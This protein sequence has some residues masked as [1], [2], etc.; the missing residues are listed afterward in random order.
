MT[1]FPKTAWHVTKIEQDTYAT[2]VTFERVSWS[3]SNSS[4]EEMEAGTAEW[5]DVEPGTPNSA[6]IPMGTPFTMPFDADAA[7]AFFIG[8]HVTFALAEVHEAEL[9]EA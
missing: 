5:F 4:E 3:D 6:W 8:Q 1:E 7:A 2:K 9:M